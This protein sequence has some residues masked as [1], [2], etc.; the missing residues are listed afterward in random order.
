MAAKDFSPCDTDI[1]QASKYI[2][3]FPRIAAT[4]FFCQAVNLP[5]VS[6][7]PT[8][9]DTP[10]S[11]LPI[12]GDKI[13]YEPLVIEFLIDEELQSW[14]VLHDWLHGIAFPTE[15]AEYKNL[16]DLSRYSSELKYPQ[17]ADAE[18]I[19]LSASNNPKIRIKFVDVFPVSLGGI[20]L[21]L[22]LDSSHIM[23]CTCTFKYSR[24]EIS[25]V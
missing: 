25:V 4:Q 24:Y 8:G 1:L 17:Y 9:I 6:T 2:L 10:F 3:T 5:G 12:P 18:L 20:N 13:Q 15:F 16:K 11:S 14:R 7:N 23:L 19:L 22:R 21:D